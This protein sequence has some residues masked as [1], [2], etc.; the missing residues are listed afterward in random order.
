M[1]CTCVSFTSV[2]LSGFVPVV[3]LPLPEFGFPADSG[4]HQ[5]L[6]L[7]LC[8]PVFLQIH[9][10]HC[11]F[12][13]RGRRY[14]CNVTSVKDEKPEKTQIYGKDLPM[15]QTAANEKVKT[16]FVFSFR[17]LNYDVKCSSDFP[18]FVSTHWIHLW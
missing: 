18:S 5:F 2:S 9:C 10:L 6:S 16:L 12:Y 14:L 7:F 3:L 1:F 8:R 17:F 11:K 4:T 15:S 13:L